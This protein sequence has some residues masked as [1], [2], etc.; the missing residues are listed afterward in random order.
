M[1]NPENIVKN[2]GISTVWTLPIIALAI[3]AW[4]IWSSFQNS[5]VD[6]T[7]IFE[8]ASGIVPGKT[9]VMAKG[10]PVG[11]VK[12]IIPD[13]ENN[14]IKAIVEMEQE[15]TKHL[16]EDTLF[17]VIRPE[18]SASSVQ[19]LDT[20]LSGSYIGIQVGS[21]TTRRLVF[22]GLDSAPPISAETPGLHL[23][24]LAEKLG[25]IQV[26][27]GIYYRN[28]QI[29]TV[30][31]YQLERNQSVLIDLFIEPD[32]SHLVREGSRFCN[33]SGL[34][35]SGKLTNLKVQVESLASLLRGGILLHTPEQL[36]ESSQ[37]ENGHV[38]SLYPDYESANYGINMTLTLSSGQDIVEGDTKV[39]YRGL[40]AGFVK[41]I[42]INNG[43]ELSVNAHILLDPRAELILRENTK[44]WLVKPKISAAGIENMRLLLAGP[45]ITFQPG[46]GEFQDHFEILPEPPPE[47]PLRNGKSFN[48]KSIN[49][50]KISANSPVYFKNIP[51]G[52][53]VGSD[54]DATG[55][56]VVT[57]IFIYEK[58]LSLVSRKS[59]FWINSGLE[60]EAGIDKGLALS[61][62]PLAQMLYGGISFMTLNSGLSHSEGTVENG[63]S[64]S[65][66]DSY[67]S[68]VAATPALQA[69]GKK[70]RIIAKDAQSLRVGSPIM[71]KN[72]KIGEVSSLRFSK[73][74]KKVVIYCF[75][76]EQYLSF[77][78]ENT[79]FY[80]ASGIQFT[81]NLDTIKLQTGS[82]QSLLAG[83]IG[84]VNPKPGKKMIVRRSYQLY[85]N[86][87]AALQT[88][89][90]KLTF[91]LEQPHGLKVGS[92]I[93]YK[94][95]TIGKIEEISFSEDLRTVISHAKIK[96]SMASLFTT[97]TI[98]WVAQL[99]LGLSGVKNLETMITGSYLHFLP[100]EGK[101][102]RS[103]KVL[104]DPPR[105]RIAS[106]NG[107]G[108]VLET[109]HL[110]SL[111]KG[112]PV[113]YRQIQVG[114]VT[115]FDLS[116][117]FQ[118]VYIYA[119]IYN[120]YRAII[121]E[122]TKF[123]NV[124]GAQI[125]GGLFSGLSISTGSLESILKGGIALATPGTEET[126]PAAFDGYH[127]ML[128]DKAEKNW[129]DWNPNII[130]L[131][132]E[133]TNEFYRETEQ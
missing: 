125:E 119:S 92:P 3:C 43:K 94:N 40:E 72:I 54:I 23:Q 124:S 91:Y 19:G 62:G 87:E 21:S 84:C 26:G 67:N 65:L 16:V 9:Q 121:R 35:I 14:N 46:S 7:I 129:L 45:H 80:N 13:L 58:Y 10:I 29:G 114:E 49:P 69:A 127:F 109:S 117:T 56:S 108:I 116:S 73:D 76:N 113:Y 71:H 52:E 112:S 18:L 77:I 107:L 97:G 96:S 4:L 41:E 78:H 24:L 104:A 47:I 17:W 120:N 103:F 100:G 20:I 34:Q 38:F 64:F 32:F 30:Q 53:V 118:K 22:T 101:P 83:G 89:K 74:K 126:K 37:A 75:I 79:R 6:I 39:M 85:E 105:S 115:D 48:L 63:D 111:S 102:S 98:V 122:N 25:S 15:I 42:T 128:H 57:T 82:L 8:D 50:V 5:G 133:Q 1:D 61:T 93:Q 60:I 99:E 33:A 70:I 123:W 106:Q 130:L 51:V 2:R 44:F 132:Q 90:T 86:L 131:D 110:G 55:E 28:I 66:F 36:R 95:I 12:K 88:D 68:A 11:L 59:I 81:A 31:K 27:T